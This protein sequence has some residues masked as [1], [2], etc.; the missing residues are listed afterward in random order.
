MHD[1]DENRPRDNTH[2]E[3]G[4]NINSREIYAFEIVAKRDDA[5]VSLDDV[6]GFDRGIL[7][8][9]EGVARDYAV[10]LFSLAR[11]C[12]EDAITSGTMKPLRTRQVC[13]ESIFPPT[14]RSVFASRR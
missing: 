5:D 6:R 3:R 11:F 13:V 4:R 7:S 2:R 8:E 12:L 9:I 1:D 10:S 14:T